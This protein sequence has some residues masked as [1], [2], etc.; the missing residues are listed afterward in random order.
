MIS[1]KWVFREVDPRDNEQIAE[2]RIFEESLTMACVNHQRRG[3]YA[4]DISD[5]LATVLP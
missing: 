1:S 3:D 4:T 2:I 5:T